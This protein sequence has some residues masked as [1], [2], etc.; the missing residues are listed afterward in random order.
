MRELDYA[1]YWHLP[2]LYSADNF[3]RSSTNVF[4]GIVSID[5]LCLPNGDAR[6]VE[7]MRAVSGP[8]DWPLAG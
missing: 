6:K 8:D 2:P 4:P 7:G 5:M 1:C 3:Y